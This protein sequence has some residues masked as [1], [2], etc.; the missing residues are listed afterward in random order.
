MGSQ[1]D[2]SIQENNGEESSV[3]IFT[4]VGCLYL[5]QI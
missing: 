5:R 1:V 2:N 3:C 4:N